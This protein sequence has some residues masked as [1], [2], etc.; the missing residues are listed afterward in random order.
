M[1]VD[2]NPALQVNQRKGQQRLKESERERKRPFTANHHPAHFIWLSRGASSQSALPLKSYRGAENNPMWDSRCIESIKLFL[3][4]S[5][6]SPPLNDSCSY[7]QASSSS[8]IHFVVSPSI[9][10]NQAFTV[11]LL[12]AFCVSSLSLSPAASHSTKVLFIPATCAAHPTVT[13]W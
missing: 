4:S 10:G 12:D 3:P 9:Y 5:K 13:S 1:F 6:H 8:F 11:K 7:D 2:W